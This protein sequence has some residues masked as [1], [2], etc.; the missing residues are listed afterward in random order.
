MNAIELPKA[1]LP[2]HNCYATGDSP[3]PRVMYNPKRIQSHPGRVSLSLGVAWQKASE[4]WLSLYSIIHMS[5]LP[6]SKST[7]PYGNVQI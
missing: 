5:R 3:V 1:L 6:L 4:P 2:V 7:E